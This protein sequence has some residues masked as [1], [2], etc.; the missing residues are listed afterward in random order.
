[1]VGLPSLINKAALS[2][3]GLCYLTLEVQSSSLLFEIS[4]RH[5]SPPLNHKIKFYINNPLDHEVKIND[6]HLCVEEGK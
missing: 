6:G 5:S 2:F 4:G 1:M 3:S